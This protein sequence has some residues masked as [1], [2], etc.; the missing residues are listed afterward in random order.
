MSRP[1]G[2]LD[3]AL[4]CNTTHGTGTSLSGPWEIPAL[5]PDREIPVPSSAESSR[6]FI[7]GSMIC[8]SRRFS[9]NEFLICLF[10]SLMK[11]LTN[12]SLLLQNTERK[13]VLMTVPH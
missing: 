8:V 6:R 2:L 10:E 4:G 9:M 3:E 5:S 11:I 1:L 13:T 12:L 7:N